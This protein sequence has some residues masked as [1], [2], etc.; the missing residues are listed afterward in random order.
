M[1][2]TKG[3]FF[4][5]FFFI[6]MIHFSFFVA[7]DLSTAQFLEL[8][9]N[10]SSTI[11]VVPLNESYKLSKAVATLSLYPQGDTQQH[12]LSLTTT[13][14]AKLFE[15]EWVFKWD[16]PT[17][18]KIEFRL[19]S[20]LMS[21]SKRIKITNTIPFLIQE[22]PAETRYYIKETSLIDFSTPEIKKLARELTEN[23][24]DL[25]EVVYILASWTQKNI[26]YSLETITADASQKASWVLEN[27]KGVCDEL[28]N[29]FIALLRSV[30]I[31]ARFVSGVSYT[32][33]GEVDD[34]GQWVPHGWAEVYL[35]EYGWIPVD[36]T[37][38]QFG[39]V[40]ATHIKLKHSLDSEAA[41]TEYDWVGYNVKLQPH[42]LNFS[43][44]IIQTGPE[45]KS[46][47]LLKL[48]PTYKKVGIGSYNQLIATVS[49]PQEYYLPVELHLSKAQ[50]LAMMSETPQR[51]LLKPHETRELVW[52]IQVD[53]SLEK[54]Y[55]YTFTTEVYDIYNTSS[56]TVFET[57]PTA[58]FYN[59]E[60]QPDL[61]K[62]PLWQKIVLKIYTIFK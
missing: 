56:R 39:M 21:E 16:K 20:H 44:N 37:Y 22:L 57:S 12:V 55:M 61:D 24:T 41:H 51:V 30:G 59:L 26:N 53:P 27:K 23:K 31:P 9:L 29:L 43:I 4:I 10:I 45:K 13:P 15:E 48:I 42:Q 33:K 14:Q 7:A 50:G 28:T 19:N 8:D 2:K 54:K 17:T 38:G 25:V 58:F 34:S 62:L 18:K 35:P 49:N 1:I 32:G 5:T 47:Y 3:I 46:E 11:N 52:T 60:L 36:V 40:D 6:I